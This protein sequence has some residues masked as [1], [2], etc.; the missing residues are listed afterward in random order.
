MSNYEFYPAPEKGPETQPAFAG[1]PPQPPPRPPK[2]TARDL[3]DP[4][5]HARRIFVAEYVEIRELAE[6]LEVK[7]FKV[8]AEVLEL[9]IFKNADEMIDFATAAKIGNK[10]GFAVE[11]LL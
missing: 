6:L 2:L 11:R 9:H 8:V 4:G 3:L 10:H 7:P 5:E 1:G